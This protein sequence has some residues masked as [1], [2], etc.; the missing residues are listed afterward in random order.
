MRNTNHNRIQGSPLKATGEDGLPIPP[1]SLYNIGGRGP[2]NLMEFVRVLAEE[3]KEAGVLGEEFNI[4]QH[5]VMLPM[6]L[7]MFLLLMLIVVGWKRIMVCA[8]DKLKDRT[9]GFCTVV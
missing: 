8:G 9:K 1:Y 4:E 2:K 3:L 7:G 6:Q 5:I